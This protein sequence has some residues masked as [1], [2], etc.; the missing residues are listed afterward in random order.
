[1]KKLS[2][3]IAV[4]LAVCTVFAGCGI[5]EIKTHNAVVTEQGA[6]AGTV[7]PSVDTSQGG[8]T[9]G[10]G[11]VLPDEPYVPDILDHDPSV[12]IGGDFDFSKTYDYTGAVDAMTRRFGSGTVTDGS[13]LM[14][15]NGTIYANTDTAQAF[16][17]GTISADVINN[18]ADAGLIFG[19]TTPQTQFFQGAGI[20]YY[21]YFVSMAGYAYLGR[22]VDNGWEALTTATIPG[23]NKST[24]YNIKAVF[25][26]N[27]IMCYLNGEYLFVYTD[28][29]ALTGTGWGIRC[30]NGQNATISNIRLTSAFEI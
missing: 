16:P 21:F 15:S 7:T 24:S 29:T 11:A 19:I 23:F 27:K 14:S 2:I 18:G 6:V 22:T 12:E 17:Y 1:M 25:K 10:G 28:H 8:G 26:G 9:T 5:S 30:N 20:S 13:Y 4:V 3:L